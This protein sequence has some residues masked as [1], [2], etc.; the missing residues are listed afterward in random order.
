MTIK[1]LKI[2]IANLIG[3]SQHGLTLELLRVSFLPG[4]LER[5]KSNGSSAMANMSN[6]WIT[7]SAVSPTAR[8]LGSLEKWIASLEDRNCRK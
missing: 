5:L 1:L 8:S 6:V 2:V 4:T 7:A 3:S